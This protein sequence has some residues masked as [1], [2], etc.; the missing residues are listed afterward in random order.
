MNRTERVTPFA[1]GLCKVLLAAILIA[2]MPAAVLPA[3]PVARWLRSPREVPGPRRGFPLPWRM[4]R[5]SRAH[6]AHHG[7]A[8]RYGSAPQ[9]FGAAAP[10]PNA[11]P[12]LSG[13]SFTFGCLNN[14]AKLSGVCLA[15]WAGVLKAVLPSS[16]P[17]VP[18]PGTVVTYD[19]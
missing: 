13:R 14:P 1:N 2:L 3:A 19:L 5:R 7:G 17:I 8:L 9:L 11:L 10:E 4:I 18:A 12:A 16:F 6:P 15:A